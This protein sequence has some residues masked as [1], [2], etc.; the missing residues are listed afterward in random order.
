MTKERRAKPRIKTDRGMIAPPP[1]SERAPST[2]WTRL[3]KKHIMHR[4]HK[5]LDDRWRLINIGNEELSLQ[6]TVNT[7][8]K[9]SDFDL[10]RHDEIKSLPGGMVAAAAELRR[11]R[12]K[13]QAATRAAQALYEAG[14]PTWSSVDAYHASFLTAKVIL[15]V[16]GI[17]IVSIDGRNFFLDLLPGEGDNAHRKQFASATKGVTDPVRFMTING[18]RIEHRH[19]WELLSRVGNKCSLEALDESEAKWLKSFD[20]S[21]YSS[22]RNKII[23]QT[24]YWTSFGDLPGPVLNIDPMSQLPAYINYKDNTW[25]EDEVKDHVLMSVLNDLSQRICPL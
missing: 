21:D 20:F 13:S 8:F 7:L 1:S 10:K 2:N 19:V 9:I 11:L 15:G 14:N 18:S 17:F 24:Y 5:D 22:V 6:E 4:S 25:L 16:F 23:Y 3:A 12:E